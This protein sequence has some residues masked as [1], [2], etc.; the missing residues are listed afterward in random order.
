[1]MV[2][3]G[4][5]VSHGNDWRLFF[6][7]IFLL[8]PGFLVGGPGCYLPNIKGKISFLYFEDGTTG[9]ESIFIKPEKKKKIA[10]CLAI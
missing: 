10:K 8:S 3:T 4:P 1:M 6:I 5:N 7:V 2:L 9:P